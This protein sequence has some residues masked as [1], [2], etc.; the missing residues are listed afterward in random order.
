MA[1]AL[2]CASCGGSPTASPN[3]SSTTSDRAATTSANGQDATVLAAYKAEQAAFA[4]AQQTA[5][6]TLPA[7]AQTMTGA[8]LI[9][10]RR[11][12]VAD[13]VNGIVGRGSVQVHPKVVSISDSQAVVRDCLFSSLELVYAATGKP[14]P[15]VTP[16]EHDAVQATLLKSSGSWKVADQQVTEGHCPAGF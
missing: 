10:V 14:V 16:P 13:Q 12:L 9:S 7:L 11:A 1:F 6:A 15:P 4:E 3:S 5:N 8:Q 2:L